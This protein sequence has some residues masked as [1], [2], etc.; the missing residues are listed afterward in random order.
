MVSHGVWSPIELYSTEDD[1]GITEKQTEKPLRAAAHWS[2]HQST[3]SRAYKLDH[4]T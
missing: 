3:M 1:R 2:K 4:T